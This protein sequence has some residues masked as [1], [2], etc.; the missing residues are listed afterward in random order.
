MSLEPTAKPCTYTLII[1]ED[2]PTMEQRLVKEFSTEFERRRQTTP[3]S[4]PFTT[5]K[6]SG[7]QSLLDIIEREE[8]NPN[9][10]YGWI[11]DWQLGGERYGNEKNT[12]SIIYTALATLLGGFS[13]A[14]IFQDYDDP[15]DLRDPD[16]PSFL[17]M[18]EYRHL[19]DAFGVQGMYQ[20]LSLVASSGFFCIYTSH[21]Q[22][23]MCSASVEISFGSVGQE[24]APLVLYKE[25][26]TN[27]RLEVAQMTEAFLIAAHAYS[28]KIPLIG[29]WE[30]NRFL[31]AGRSQLAPEVAKSYSVASCFGNKL[32]DF[33]LEHEL[34]QRL[35]P[36][37]R[38][39]YL[40]I[41]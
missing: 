18:E 32:D 19:K 13:T 14:F 24:E 10:F 31:P 35:T 9:A 15:R 39:K 5:S 3:E 22:K 2:E 11:T 33:V 36:Q 12:S 1:L 4:G 26:G 37:E 16:K 23:P 17:M 7:H 34:R 8:F 20:L 29:K 40:N 25:K 28:G 30:A 27:L 21:P 6:I 41:S 38:K